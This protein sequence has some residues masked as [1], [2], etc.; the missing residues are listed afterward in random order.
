MLHL[1]VCRMGLFSQ[2]KSMRINIPPL[3]MEVGQEWLQTVARAFC[4]PPNSSQMKHL[5]QLTPPLQ[6]HPSFL[7]NN[8]NA[9][10]LKK[11]FDSFPY[12]RCHRKLIF[13]YTNW[14]HHT[15]NAACV[16]WSAFWGISHRFS[17]LYHREGCFCDSV[18]V[19]ALCES[20]PSAERNLTPSLAVCLIPES[21][22][23]KATS[24]ERGETRSRRKD[25]REKKEQLSFLAEASERYEENEPKIP[26]PCVFISHMP[27][28]VL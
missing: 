14:A 27:I 16:I 3:S 28:L 7:R 20:Q 2:I 15:K 4:G 23:S 10:G 13:F 21:R 18:L 26:T 19:L 12:T 6:L 1:I 8:K 5:C 24:K 17:W 9:R 11:G 25:L 22:E